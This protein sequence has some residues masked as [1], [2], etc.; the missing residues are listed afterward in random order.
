LF[1][2]L[3]GLGA[4]AGAQLVEG[5]AAV[6]FDGVLTDEEAVGDL[7][8]AETLSDEAE[9]FEL[10]RR[11]AEGVKLGLVEGE[12][13][14]RIGGDK[15]FAEDDFLAGFGELDTEPDAEGDEDD[16]DNGAIDLER[17]LDDEKLVFG[18]AEDGDENAA[19]ETENHDMAEGMALHGCWV[20]F[21]AVVDNRAN[22]ALAAKGFLT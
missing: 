3:D 20:D 13:E 12:G 7:A 17:M 6:G 2:E 11:N 22:A 5:S 14:W 1:A 9:D 15:D 16:S 18:P 8:V 4:A 10:T 21:T 19:D